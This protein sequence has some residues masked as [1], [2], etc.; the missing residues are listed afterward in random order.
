MALDEPRDSDQQYK[1]NGVTWL[2]ARDDHDSVLG[3]H[4][5][6]VDHVEGWFGSGFALTRKGQLACC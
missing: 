2:V 4:G 3:P 5:I 1:T 6:R